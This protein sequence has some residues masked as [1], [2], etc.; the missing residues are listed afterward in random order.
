MTGGTAQTAS[1]HRARVVVAAGLAA[2]VAACLLFAPAAGGSS[3]ADDTFTQVDGSPNPA[4]AGE[5]V[6]IV[7]RQCNRSRNVQATGTI[8]FTDLTTGKSL[9]TGKLG[10]VESPFVN[11]GDTSISGQ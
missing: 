6:T 8:V 9:G 2:L 5:L 4:A 11:C 10:S 3:A 1:D 7:G